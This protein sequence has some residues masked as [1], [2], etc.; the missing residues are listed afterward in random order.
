MGGLMRIL[1]ELAMQ[2]RSYQKPLQFF[3]LLLL[4][5]CCHFR[6]SLVYIVIQVKN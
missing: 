6:N 4:L 2:E 3:V 1:L 5:L